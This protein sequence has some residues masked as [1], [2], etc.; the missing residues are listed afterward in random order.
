MPIFTAGKWQNEDLKLESPR[1][2]VVGLSFKTHQV[3][4]RMWSHLWL[5]KHIAY[6]SVT[7]DM[8]FIVAAFKVACQL[9]IRSLI[10]KT[11]HEGCLKV[12]MCNIIKGYI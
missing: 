11:L 8:L 7:L 9:L 6:R 5:I 10:E 12:I 2:K 4:K 3:C 1:W